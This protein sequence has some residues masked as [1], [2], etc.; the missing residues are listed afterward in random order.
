ME[1]LGLYDKNGNYLNETIDRKNKLLVPKDK[2]YKQVIVFTINNKGQY[3]IQKSSEKKGN[4]FET[5][6]GHVK[7]KY[8]CKETIIEEFMEELSINVVKRDIV[9]FKKYI[10]NNSIQEVYYI[11]GNIDINELIYQSDEVSYATWFSIDEIKELIKNNKFRKK[12]IIPFLEL[13]K[14]L[15]E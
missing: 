11:R 8:S 10:Y 12:N 9:F 15:E 2:Y 7:D 6:G 13:I 14:Y 4:I 1:I 3:L 5:L